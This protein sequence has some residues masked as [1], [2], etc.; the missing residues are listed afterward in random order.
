[1]TVRLSMV[2]RNLAQE[3]PALGGR[4]PAFLMIFMGCLLGCGLARGHQTADQGLDVG[5]ALSGDASGDDLVYLVSWP[6]NRARTELDR[7]WQ[8]ALGYVEIDGRLGQVEDLL[9]CREPV[10]DP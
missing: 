8:Q 3:V 6:A 1:M 4:P 10:N 7:A 2:C 9:Y 5:I